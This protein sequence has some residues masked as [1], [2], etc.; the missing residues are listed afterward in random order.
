MSILSEYP[1]EEQ[2]LLLRGLSAAAIAVSAASLGRARET[3]AEGFAAA[4]YIIEN[5]GNYL[6]N[7]LI[8]S[9]QYELE[10]RAAN[11]APF[12]D[13]QQQVVAESAMEDALA[14]LRAVAALLA[15]RTT[16]E[17]AAGYARWL[18]NIARQTAL[19]GAEGGNWLGWGAV[20]VNQAEEDALAQVAQA[21]GLS[22]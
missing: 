2:L 1:A 16:P 12:P 11:G 20:Q 10:V 22:A 8:G 21:L 6:D 5:K 15:A 3:A 17:E 14:T 4:R 19:G 18:L 7:S 9:V 13:F